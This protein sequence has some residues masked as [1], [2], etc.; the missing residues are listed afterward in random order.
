MD[1]TRTKGFGGAIPGAASDST[2][3]SQKALIADL[4]RKGRGTTKLTPFGRQHAPST[5]KAFSGVS[6]DPLNDAAKALLES[7]PAQDQGQTRN[8]CIA[9]ATLAMVELFDRLHSDGDSFTNYS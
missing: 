2:V 6:L 1:N 8:T 5:P 7:W 4:A 3:A 9:F